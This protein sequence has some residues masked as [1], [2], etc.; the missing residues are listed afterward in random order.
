M[1]IEFEITPIKRWPDGWDRH[2]PPTKWSP[3]TGSWNS[4]RELLDREL[5]HLR[6]KEVKLQ[7]DVTDYQVRR[8]GML[9]SDTKVTYPGVILGFNT[10]EWGGL[11]YPCNA[12]ASNYKQPAWQANVRAIA[13][14]LEALRRVE[15]YGIANRGQQYAGFAELGS[16]IAMGPMSSAQA[17]ELLLKAVEAEEDD[18][19]SSWGD[20]ELF[21]RAA[22]KHHPDVG[23]DPDYFKLLVEAR[24][25]LEAS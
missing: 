18:D 7:L 13:L 12:F 15:R 11:S 4:T 20:G 17:L 16:G 6:A 9:R 24:D 22:M 8:D 19:G 3:F 21:R 23:G 2:R 5:S 10:P 25:V 14:G 1:T